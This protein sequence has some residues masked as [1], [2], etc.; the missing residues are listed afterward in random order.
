[1]PHRA[2]ARRARRC[3]LRSGSA[4]A[5]LEADRDAL[6]Q[7]QRRCLEARGSWPS[8]TARA[9]ALLVRAGE[10]EDASEDVEAA[11]T[12][13]AQARSTLTDLTEALNEED[14]TSAA[15]ARAASLD[16]GAIEDLTATVS[17]AATAP[18]AGPAGSGGP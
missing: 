2:G 13:L 14:F 1:M 15:Q 18:R 17:T 4:R 8:V 6:A 11:R 10:A 5:R 12:A 16:R 3:P 9:A 7:D